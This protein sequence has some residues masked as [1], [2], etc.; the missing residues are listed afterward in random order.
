[1][2]NKLALSKGLGIKNNLFYKKNDLKKNLKCQ[3]INF[4]TVFDAIKKTFSASQL[5]SHRLIDELMAIHFLF[6][7]G[8][9][10]KN[11]GPV[12][13]NFLH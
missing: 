4:S 9:L 6:L 8:S 7:P 13:K 11:L 3:K 10:M 5:S 2:G 1:L 12:P